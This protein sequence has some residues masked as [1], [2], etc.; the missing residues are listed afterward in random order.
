MK[1]KKAPVEEC[2]CVEFGAGLTDSEFASFCKTPEAIKR[3]VTGE[4]SEVGS[5]TKFV[6]GSGGKWTRAEWKA[7]FKYDPK[8]AWDRM[9][10]L[11][12]V[13]V[14]GHK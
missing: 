2:E 13:T 11:N 9:K 12:I 8:P 5:E 6:D 10:R 3:I 14:G 1:F 7:R 4:I